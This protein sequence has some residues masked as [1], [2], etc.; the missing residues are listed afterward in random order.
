[1]G[2]IYSG[3]GALSPRSHLKCQVLSSAIEWYYD[4]NVVWLGRI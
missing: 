1:M 2:Y 3:K 4:Q